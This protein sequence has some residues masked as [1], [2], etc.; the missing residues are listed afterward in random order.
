MQKWFQF[1]LLLSS[2]AAAADLA[3]ADRFVIRR[4][5][6][7]V[8]LQLRGKGPVLTMPDALSRVPAPQLYLVG[9]DLDSC[10]L[11]LRIGCVHKVD[12]LPFFV[13]LRFASAAEASTVARRIAGSDSPPSPTH[14]GPIVIHA[15]SLAKLTIFV[16]DKITVEIRVRCLQS[17][18]LDKV[19]QVRD[20][21][22]GRL[23]RAR[24]LGQAELRAE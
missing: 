13:L 10:S 3:A 4:E 20:E 9:E 7:F 12:C 6:V 23:Y 17:G 21:Q 16:S 24:V 8:F 11:R 19:I 1:V 2:L 22:T 14:S 5:Q 15:G 18:G